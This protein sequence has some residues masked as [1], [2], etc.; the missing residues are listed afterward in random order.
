MILLISAAI[1][2]LT[3]AL[4]LVLIEFI[5][6]LVGKTY[7]G[8]VG[9]DLVTSFGRWVHASWN[10]IGARDFKMQHYDPVRHIGVRW[11]GHEWEE[12]IEI[13]MGELR[14]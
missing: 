13:Q 10:Y 11:F 2:L 14:F 9:L 3:L 1:T 8:Y 4:I 7:Q 12:L 6:S 5:I